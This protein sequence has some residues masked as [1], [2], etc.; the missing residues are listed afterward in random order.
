MDSSP[1]GLSGELVSA[2]GLIAGC[3]V[4]AQRVKLRG[5]RPRSGVGGKADLPVQRPDFSL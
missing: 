2:K 4:I 1:D 3:P 5:A